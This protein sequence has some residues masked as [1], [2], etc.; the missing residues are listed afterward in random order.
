MKNFLIQFSMFLLLSLIA[1][2][3]PAAQGNPDAFFNT[4]RNALGLRLG[5]NRLNLL[6]RNSSALI[7]RGNIP[8]VGI[9]Y[10][11]YGEN[12]YF[13]ANLQAGN[14]S[15]FTKNHPGRTIYFMSQDVHGHVDTVA[16]P[17]RG[18]STL[19]RLARA[20][21]S[22]RVVA[23]VE[24]ES[25]DF[26][27]VL[28]LEVLPLP[29]GVCNPHGTPS[30]RRLFQHVLSHWSSGWCGFFNSDMVF[31]GSLVAT[32]RAVHA[33]VASGK[34][35]KRVLVVG[36]RSNFMLAPGFDV[37]KIAPKPGRSTDRLITAWLAV[38]ESGDRSALDFFIFTR[39]TF[40]WSRMPDMVS[41][42]LLTSGLNS[43][44]ASNMTVADRLL[45]GSGTT[46]ASSTW[47]TAAA[48]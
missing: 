16:V 17:V 13:I 33:S 19:S 24:S 36:S 42:T 2:Q 43:K 26:A 7:Y 23:F 45:G 1:L 3:R 20:N 41:Q 47:P 18:S 8:M 21:P 14:G 32:L 38:A 12:G 4:R 6:D 35:R 11:T 31:D 5:F 27:K 48:R 29:P 46:T 44:S 37:G 9:E 25:W 22:L 30:V 10:Q 15:F 40:D 28:G 34:L 39:P